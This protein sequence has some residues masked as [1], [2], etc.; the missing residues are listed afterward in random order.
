[1]KNAIGE[2]MWWL[3]HLRIDY[4]SHLSNVSPRIVSQASQELFFLLSC[5]FP[6]L[7]GVPAFLVLQWEA[8]RQDV[9]YRVA[10]DPEMPCLTKFRRVSISV[11]LP[12]PPCEARR[13]PILI[14]LMDGT[15]SVDIH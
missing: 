11:Y 10:K 13:P 3:N 7:P 1:M 9:F 6:F 2:Q 14:E 15:L 12:S 4:L 5:G 8:G